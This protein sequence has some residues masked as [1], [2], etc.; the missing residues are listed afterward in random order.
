[1]RV[2]DPL[3]EKAI[4]RKAM[5][6]AAKEG[7]DGLSMQKIAKAAKVS[8]GTLYI[9]FKDREDLILQVYQEEMQKTFAATM[10]NFDPSMRFDEGLRVQWLNRARYCMKN[11][12]SMQF[13]EQFRHTPLHEKALGM[14]G[15][16]PFKEIM[17]TFLSNAIRNGELVKVPVEV[18]WA[19]AF[20]P[21]YQL[22]KFH[23]QGKS[24]PGMGKFVLSE[25]LL[26]QTLSLVLKSLKPATAGS[27]SAPAPRKPVGAPQNKNNS[28]N[29][30][31]LK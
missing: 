18:Y 19:V 11:P 13:M 20:A 16:P 24:L 30:G 22:V 1:M 29:K 7:F 6:M 26:M 10:E 4:R 5:E 28:E 9:Y 31:K 3:K 21:M 17:R 12:L 27:A 14:V 8:P 2:R 23:L 25:D 15:A